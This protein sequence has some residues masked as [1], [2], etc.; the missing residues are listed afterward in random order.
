MNSTR[1][2]F[3]R[4]AAAFG[5]VALAAAP[6][7]A[8]GPE[9]SERLFTLM[10]STNANVLNYDAWVKPDGNLHPKQPI[11]AYWLMKAG[12]GHREDLTW[13]EKKFAYGFDVTPSEKDGT[14]VLTLIAYKDRPLRVGKVDGK[15]RA[16][17]IIN[18]KKAY[19]DKLFIQVEE[20]GISPNVKY[21]ELFGK[22]AA[23]GAAVQ[24]RVTKS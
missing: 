12:D 24:E 5:L 6:A 21:V 22:D 14:Y 1:R 8:E 17:T 18:G 23:S 2:T 7:S 19:L 9:R 4:T 16:L 11:V 13:T 20:G 10:R 15:W 3:L